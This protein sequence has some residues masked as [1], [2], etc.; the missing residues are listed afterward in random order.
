MLRLSNHHAKTPNQAGKGQDRPEGAAPETQGRLAGT[1]RKGAGEEAPEEGLAEAKNG[2]T[3]NNL[4]WIAFVAIMAVGYGVYRLELILL[5]IEA[6]LKR[7]V[8]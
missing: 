8:G 4:E 7:Q 5:R 2:E 3:M 6:L 1:G